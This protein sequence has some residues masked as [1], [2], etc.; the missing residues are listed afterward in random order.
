[1][2]KYLKLATICLLI[3]SACKKND[4]TVQSAEGPENSISLRSCASN[5]VL[6]QQLAADPAFRDRLNAIERFTKKA[7]ENKELARLLPGGVIE[8]PVV[9][10][11]LYRTEAENIS[12]EQIKSQIDVLN[13]DFSGTNADYKSVPD[14]FKQSKYDFKVQFVLKTVVRKACKQ[15]TWAIT[16]GMKKSNQGGIDPTDPLTTLNM[17]SCNL[18]QNLLGYAQFPGGPLATDGVVILYSAFGSKYKFSNGTYIA[19]YDKGRTATHEVGHWMNLYHIWGDATC[20][21]DKVDDTPPHNAANFGCPDEKAI[22]CT[23]NAIT[24][25]YGYTRE[26]TMNY[27]DYSH[28]ACMYLFSNGQKDRMLAVFATGGPREAIGK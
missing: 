14:M 11:V 1:M 8:I 26:M 4:N 20:G 5:E 15:K 17:W 18:G 21:T 6:Q 12:D 28:D 19:N 9:V 16:D 24:N 3:L 2:R 27:M 25:P 7:I 10:N 23:N 22:T 13:E